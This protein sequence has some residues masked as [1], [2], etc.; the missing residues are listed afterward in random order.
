MTHRVS[1]GGFDCRGRKSRVH[2]V[3]RLLA[4]VDLLQGNGLG[5]K[6]VSQFGQINPVPQPLLQ[7]RGGGQLLVQTGL[8]PSAGSRTE[9]MEKMLLHGHRI[10]VISFIVRA[11]DQ[12]KMLVHR[13]TCTWS[14]AAAFLPV[15]RAQR[16]HLGPDWRRVT[17]PRPK[18]LNKTILFGVVQTFA[19]V[20]GDATT[21]RGRTVS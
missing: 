10:T 2:L 20:S 3:A 13:H 12:R 16:Q 14:C 5:G 1:L 18:F 9:H 8:H 6:E 4:V 21:K 17:E 7:L 19:R 11:S 15:L